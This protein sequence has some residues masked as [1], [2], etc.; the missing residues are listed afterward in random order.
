M[1]FADIC[2]LLDFIDLMASFLHRNLMGEIGREHARLRADKIHHIGQS[3]LVS[4][5]AHIKARL[6]ALEAGRVVAI[7]ITPRY[8]IMGRQRP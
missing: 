4:L 7:I 6:A 3:R 8:N 2:P 1:F 5:S